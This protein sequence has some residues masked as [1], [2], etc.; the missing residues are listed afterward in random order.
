VVKSLPLFAPSRASRDYFCVWNQYKN[1]MND[2]EASDE[3][4]AK[5]ISKTD[6]QSVNAGLVRM[7]QAS[8]EKLHAEEVALEQSAAAEIKANTVSTHMSALAA[9]E[10]EEVLS[11]KTA[12]GYVQ[13]EKA[14]VS[15]YT[16]LV[17]A[18]NAEVHYGLTGVVV[19]ENVHVEG[20]R[21]IL[22]VGEH[23]TG[24]VT[25]LV[26]PRSAL[27]AGL[28]GG[29]FAGLMLLLGHMLFGRK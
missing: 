12:I 13:A 1:S 16:A 21:T 28:T 24:T 11:Q 8:A 6:I 18:Q 29:L 27:I 17:A 2:P 19:G 26:S 15:G 23:V 3:L 9:V 22:L 20:A 10:A 25:T 14:S 4:Q 5:D 7:H